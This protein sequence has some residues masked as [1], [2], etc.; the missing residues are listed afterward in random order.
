[1]LKNVLVQGPGYKKR[2]FGHRVVYPKN[3]YIVYPKYTV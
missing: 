3:I 1:M 2:P